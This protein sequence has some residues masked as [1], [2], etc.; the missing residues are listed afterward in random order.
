MVTVA[1]VNVSPVQTFAVGER[2][3]RSGIL[4]APVA[5]RVMVRMLGI[6]GDAQA[7]HRF[8]G[9]PEKAVYLYGAEHY[10]FWRTRIR[11]KTLERL[12]NLPYGIFGENLTIAGLGDLEA[13]LHV[14]DVLK[15]GDALL[16]LT[17]PRQPCWKLETRFAIP[18]FARAFLGSGRLGIY[19]RVRH[20]GRVG[21]GDAVE[22][23]ER[24]ADSIPLA[25]LILALYFDDEA[26][27][28]RALASG[29]L[30]PRLR[31]RIERREP[32]GE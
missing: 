31:R 30:P 17:D 13:K 6:D 23:V 12:G 10:D 18:D 8:H 25:D 28:A 26:A 32:E 21:A 15:A 19:A 4:K 29:S 11:G 3:V 16:E 14:G 1:S 2:K 22:V 7:D 9:G 5:G 24:A 20:E 27:R